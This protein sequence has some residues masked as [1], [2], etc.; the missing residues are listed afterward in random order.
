MLRARRSFRAGLRI[1]QFGD[2]HCW[3]GDFFCS[4]SR[5]LLCWRTGARPLL[6]SGQKRCQR[7]KRCLF[8]S[9]PIVAAHNLGVFSVNCRWDFFNVAQCR[10]SNRLLFCIGPHW[11]KMTWRFEKA[12]KLWALFLSG[13]A[14]VVW[15]FLRFLKKK[16][17][18]FFFQH[19]RKNS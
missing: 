2:F 14:S 13:F 16:T 4:V 6:K 19:L 18:F 7:V 12:P 15:F 8:G 10:K 1:V 5:F 9:R 11:K 17:F 3:F